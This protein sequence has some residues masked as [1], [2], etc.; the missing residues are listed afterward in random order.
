MKINLKK[1]KRK[2]DISE[3]IKIYSMMQTKFL[4]KNK[5]TKQNRKKHK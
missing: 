1:K 2:H 3:Q 5:Q 4:K